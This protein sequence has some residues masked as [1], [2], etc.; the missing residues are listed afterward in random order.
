MDQLRSTNEPSSLAATF[1]RYS[2]KSLLRTMAVLALAYILLLA[3]L[4][5]SY[6]AEVDEDVRNLMGGS[7]GVS[8]LR[9]ADRV[10]AYRIGPTGTGG[11]LDAP[12]I[13][14][15]VA[16]SNSVARTIRRV[17]EDQKSY[18]WSAQKA[19]KPMPGVRLD[20]IR[21]NERLSV[22]VCFECD[23]LFYYLNGKQVGAKD[24][25]GAGPALVRA[26]CSIFPDDPVI[27]S[28]R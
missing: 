1:P 28:F 2:V 12:I 8:V 17:L 18:L 19:C 14:G 6:E 15:P 3:Y 20:F 5:F 9:N 21:G 27:Q 26:A 10:E 4:H 24:C 7:A 11:Y 23:F 16:V 22:L 25:D 13:K